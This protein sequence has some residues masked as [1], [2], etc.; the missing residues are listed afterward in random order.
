VRGVGAVAA[1]TNF[2]LV[3]GWAAI[4][5]LAVIWFIVGFF[6]ALYIL[7]WGLSLTFL[8]L[9]AVFQFVTLP[10]RKRANH[11]NRIKWFEDLTTR[12]LRLAYERAEA[13][14][15]DPCEW[16]RDV[17]T[18]PPARRVRWAEDR[19]DDLY[20]MRMTLRRRGENPDLKLLA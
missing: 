18:A 2:A 11:L 3:I 12:D 6:V 17:L 16:P 1:V 20:R 7:W 8:A 13:A 10:V 14:M 19:R 15:R 5:L 9:R 4:A